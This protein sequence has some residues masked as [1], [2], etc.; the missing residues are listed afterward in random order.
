LD[1]GCFRQSDD[2]IWDC[3]RVEGGLSSQD[4]FPV[5]SPGVRNARATMSFL[6]FSCLDLAIGEFSKTKAR[7]EPPSLEE[8]YSNKNNLMW[9][10]LWEERPIHERVL[11]L[12]LC[13]E[14]GLLWSR[15]C[16]QSAINAFQEPWP[17]YQARQNLETAK[18][19]KT[20]PTSDAN[21]HKI[22]TSERFL[23]GMERC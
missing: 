21:V 5:G 20:I 9:V 19:A 22:L 23:G 17:L 2:G 14:H 1:D 10:A 16:Y 4:Y 6:L 13:R 12:Y 15:R 3:A 8:G 7:P 18:Q 11:C